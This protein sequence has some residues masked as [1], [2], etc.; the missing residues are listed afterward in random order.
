MVIR[1]Y[2][3]FDPIDRSLRYVGRTMHKLKKRLSGH[4]ASPSGAPMRGWVRELKA[5][6]L[7]PT[8]ELIETVPLAGAAAREAY[9]IERCAPADLL[10]VCK[11]A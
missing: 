3:L 10:N 5:N 8:I 7:R 6:G 2:G 4:M 1:I 9:W 11:M